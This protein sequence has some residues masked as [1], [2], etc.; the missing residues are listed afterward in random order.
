MKMFDCVLNRLLSCVRV[1]PKLA[2][3]LRRY[4]DILWRDL[5]DVWLWNSKRSTNSLTLPIKSAR[6]GQS[7]RSGTVTLLIWQF[8]NFPAKL[9]TCS[10]P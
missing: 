8:K 9:M 7:V 5:P 4:L 10:T 1:W 2:H 3:Y 6:C